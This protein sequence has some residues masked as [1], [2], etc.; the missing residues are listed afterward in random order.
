MAR[1]QTTE[2]ARPTP[3]SARKAIS[4][5]MVD[6]IAAPVLAGRAGL[7]SSHALDRAPSA[8]VIINA[9]SS[10][11]VAGPLALRK[12]LF[13]GCRVAYD[14]VYASRPTAFMQAASAAGVPAVSDGLGMLVEQAAESFMLWR[15][16]RPDSAPVY[17][18]L[19]EAVDAGR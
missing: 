3:C 4:M 13:D 8:D 14:C 11:I 18:M 12:D 19:R 15:G 2:A 5:P 7:L 16:L 17:R 9:T 1:A 6:D 10:G